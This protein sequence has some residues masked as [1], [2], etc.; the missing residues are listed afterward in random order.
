MLEKGGLFPSPVEFKT[1]GYPVPDVAHIPLF[2][3]V[4][5]SQRKKEKNVAE[6]NANLWQ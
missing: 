1:S 4:H 6:R 5:F 3:F 2:F